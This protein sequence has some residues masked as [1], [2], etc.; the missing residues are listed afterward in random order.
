MFAFTLILPIFKLTEF[1]CHTLLVIRYNH[2]SLKTTFEQLILI[3]KY[4]TF[5]FE[6]HLRLLFC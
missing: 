2:V 1:L 6:C 5:P 3:K 4:H